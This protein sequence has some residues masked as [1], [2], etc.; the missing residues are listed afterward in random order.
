MADTRQT[1]FNA[2]G[3]GARDYSGEFADQRHRARMIAAALAPHGPF[4]RAADVGCFGGVAAETYKTAGISRIDGFDVADPSLAAFRARGGEAWRWDAGREPFPAD[5]HAYDVVIASEMIEHVDDTEHALREFHKAL[6]PGG[7]LALTT[8]NQVFW[9][10]R[11]RVLAGRAPMASP[12]VAPGR[13]HDSAIDPLHA[14]IGTLAEWQAL[15]EA[16]G[17][18]VLSVSATSY[19]QA[20]TYPR[21]WMAWLDRVIAT[22]PTLGGNLIFLARAV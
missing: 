20:D 15:I 1:D 21:R 19:L 14:R 6:R 13:A 10:S 11:L 4:A 18:Q 2:R 12:G 5:A 9:Y 8:P 7:L 17:F 22:R 16:C 3:F